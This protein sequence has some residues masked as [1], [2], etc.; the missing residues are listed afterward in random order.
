MHLYRLNGAG[1]ER[2]S[3]RR[4]RAATK[5]FSPRRAGGPSAADYF[6]LPRFSRTIVRIEPFPRAMQAYVY[7][8]QRKPDTYVYV[9]G[10]D[11]FSALPA[12]LRTRL[13]VL[14]F[15]LE[16]AL[17]ADRRLAREDPALV[18]R[19]LAERGYHLQMPPSAAADPMHGDWGTDA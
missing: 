19:N 15:V 5:A 3:L 14:E 12:A 1:R 11:D 13:G 9:A 8:S 6:R 7:K 4:G 17:T 18:R 10:R 2:M 16:V